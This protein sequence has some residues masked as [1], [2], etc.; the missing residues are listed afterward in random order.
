MARETLDGNPSGDS[1]PE[2][3]NN[4]Y[5]PISDGDVIS[6]DGIDTTDE[7]ASDSAINPG[8]ILR[9]TEGD[10]GGE[11]R[12][13]RKY[14]KRN[15]G[16]SGRKANKEASQDLSGVLFTMHFMLAKLMDIEEVELDETEAKK[17]SDAVVRVNEL[18]D[19]FIIPEKAMAWLSLAMVAGA[20]YGPRVAAYNLRMSTKP[21]TINVVPTAVH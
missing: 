17:L 4:S 9:G 3:G 7:R 10:S 18:Y 16:T 19:G 8:D 6:A 11:P 1:K 15:P 14:T 2:I 12:A 21:K 13:K 5:S 20:I